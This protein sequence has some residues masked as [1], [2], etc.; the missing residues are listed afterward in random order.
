MSN[1]AA[2]SSNFSALKAC[3]HACHGNTLPS[4]DPALFYSAISELMSG[5]APDALIASFLTSFHHTKFSPL[6]ISQCAKAMRDAGITLRPQIDIS[7]SV[8]SGVMDIV[9][10][11]G[12]GLDTFNVSTASSLIVAATGQA[13]V[14]H[15]NRS[16]SS[17][18]GSADLLEA[19]GIKFNFSSE[20]AVR[21]LKD[22]NYLFL[23]APAYHPAMKF[24]SS[25]RKMLGFRTIFNVMGP[26]TNPFSPIKYQLTGVYDYN[27]GRIVAETLIELGVHRAAIV[28]SKEGMDEISC[29]DSTHIWLVNDKQIQEFD[30]SPADFGLPLH[31]LNSVASGTASENLAILHRIFAGEQLP[32][33]DY[34]LMNTAAAL[35]VAE[36]AKDWKEGVKLARETIN[37]GKAKELLLKY[38]AATQQAEASSAAGHQTVNNCNGLSNNSAHNSAENGATEKKQSFLEKIAAHR[39]TLIAESK[40]RVSLA[41]LYSLALSS[42]VP[43]L[44]SVLARVKN[45]HKISLAAEIKR[46]S[47]SAGAINMAINVAEQARD[48][49]LG[50]AALIS[51]LTEP[52]WFKGSLEDLKLARK[53]VE[54]LPN[55]PAILLKDFVL[56]EY[57][58][59]E[60]RIAG[61]DTFLL[62][63]AIL[64]LEKLRNLIEFGRNLGM[65]PLV[66]VANERELSV[67]LESGAEFIGVNNRDLH[68]FSVNMDT[69]L[70]IAEKL[71]IHYKKHP[72][73]KKIT[74]AALSGIKTRADVAKYQAAGT[75]MVLVGET[76]MKSANPRAAIS[77]LL[78]YNAEINDKPNKTYVKICG[79]TSVE[80][81]RCAADSGADFIGLIFAQSKRQVSVDQAKIIVNELK[82][83]ETARNQYSSSLESLIREKRGRP[84]AV[85]VFVDTSPAEINRISEE[86]GLDLIQ[87]HGSEGFS[88]V[89]Q[90]NRPVIRSVSVIPGKTTAA[91]ILSQLETEAGAGWRVAAI[92]LD[93]KSESSSVAGGTGE[94]FDWSIA[95]AVN[96]KFPVILAGGLN[97]GNVRG[98][99]ELVSPLAVDV[100]SGV[101][102]SPGV[103]DFT[104]IRKFIFNAKSA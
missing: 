70:F 60:A 68:T 88:P 75:E 49:A 61:A 20:E 73:A 98:A 35:V 85:G 56:D 93:T 4:I 36:K 47:P 34:V 6:L 28:H 17:K 65:E 90:L 55:R 48:Y 101:E 27:L 104:A 30:V 8:S 46:A 50:G 97:A 83:A 64:S 31:S 51:V 62:I 11:G 23:F 41:S 96:L 43:T 25:T 100:A 94:S 1:P 74:L 84:L 102:F 53:T 26:L 69:T 33:T 38:I 92:L 22:T 99:V 79:I 7:T 58:I 3:I 81:A 54:N 87:L 45:A 77:E 2:N 89:S 15:G 95:A 40:S 80:A 44:V 86:V 91:E 76:L 66:E 19:A 21:V 12:D 82:S 37:S 32:Q 72:Q 16:S 13:I 14:K 29:N 10:T 71:E 59:I 78:G 63:V 9:G 57:Q 67:A 39:L 18:C 5:T 24:V 42:P 103:K 52:N